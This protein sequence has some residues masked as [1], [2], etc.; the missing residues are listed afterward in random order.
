MRVGVER[1]AHRWIPVF[2][3]SVLASLTGSRNHS[4]G[5]VNASMYDA[6]R[7]N[8]GAHIDLSTT[9]GQKQLSRR[10]LPASTTTGLNAAP[11]FFNQGSWAVPDNR[12]STLTAT[13][14]AERGGPSLKNAF[15]FLL[16]HT[17]RERRESE[18]PSSIVPVDSRM[19]ASRR[20]WCVTNASHCLWPRAVPGGIDPVPLLCSRAFSKVEPG[21]WHPQ[22]PTKRRS[23]PVKHQCVHSWTPHL[24]VDRRSPTSITTLPAKTPWLS[25]YSINTTHVAPTAS[26]CARLHATADAGRSLFH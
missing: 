14:W 20:H 6:S 21:K 9:S 13:S 16:Y 5:R 7:A 17:A 8:H 2:S 24:S 19:I 22:C 1:G 15:R 23:R 25:K 10:P 11:F 26:Q 18:T 4:G 12:K 3:P